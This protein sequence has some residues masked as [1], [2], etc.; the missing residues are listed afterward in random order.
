MNCLWLRALDMFLSRSSTW[1]NTEMWVLLLRES[2]TSPIDWKKP[3]QPSAALCFS[4]IIV[5]GSSV[6][7]VCIITC[8]Y[9]FICLPAQLFLGSEENLQNKYHGS[10]QR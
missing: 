5:L 7:V 1:L 2:C 10:T 9:H 3:E 4:P 6:I 8:Y